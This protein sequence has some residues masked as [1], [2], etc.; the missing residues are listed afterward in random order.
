VLNVV[1]LGFLIDMYIGRLLFEKLK[2]LDL[3]AFTSP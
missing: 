1:S 2:N 3:S